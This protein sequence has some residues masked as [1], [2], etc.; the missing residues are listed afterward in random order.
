MK[1]PFD[2]TYDITKQEI[3]NF[4][5]LGRKNRF[6]KLKFSYNDLHPYL[7]KQYMEYIISREKELRSSIK[8][9]HSLLSTISSKFLILIN[10]LFFHE[11]L[12]FSQLDVDT[13]SFLIKLLK[14]EISL[15]EAL[16]TFKKNGRIINL[17]LK[18]KRISKKFLKDILKYDTL[19][20]CVTN[21]VD[22][23]FMAGIVIDYIDISLSFN[24][25]EMD[26]E[27]Q[28]VNCLR[29][30]LKLEY[31]PQSATIIPSIPKELYGSI[32]KIYQLMCSFISGDI[33]EQSIYTF[34]T[35]GE[36]HSLV[37]LP[38]NQV[39]FRENC[40]LLQDINFDS[41]EGIEIFERIVGNRFKYYRFAGFKHCYFDRSIV[42]N[43]KFI[44]SNIYFDDCSFNKTYQVKICK[45]GI[46][47]RFNKCTFFGKVVFGKNASIK[48]LPCNI[49]IR[50][51]IFKPGSSIEIS[52]ITETKGLTFGKVAFL[53]TIFNGNFK[54]TNLSQQANTL[55][56]IHNI[57][58][59]TPFVIENCYFNSDTVIDGLSFAITPKQAMSG[60]IKAFAKTLELSG[61]RNIA[62]ENELLDN[63]MSNN[64]ED[65]EADK[66]MQSYKLE[67]DS[68]FLKPKYAA[69]Y[70]G[71]SKDNLA[72][73]RM[74]DKRQITRESIPYV[75]EGKSIAY[76]LDALKAFKASDWALLK[77]L[78][79]KYAKNES[80]NSD[81]E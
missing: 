1:S 10:E 18:N 22:D 50:D 4:V 74:A 37:P 13:K 52:N 9:V 68:G 78:R 57:A 76:P 34:E 61:L 56:S 53:N 14:K 66:D 48:Y 81:S 11:F 43:D 26:K 29:L 6:D 15:K 17:L 41:E 58:I 12:A 28:L 5:F 25:D 59:T 19:G 23:D 38:E 30:L 69:Y 65:N 44:S 42:L 33:N 32:T 63:E 77:E 27:L 24:E 40:L 75:G 80:A 3:A 54:L 72:K 16:K 51:S 45:P 7:L 47:M 64:S 36:N 20:R 71:M 46:L 70:L 21:G 60:A 39:S 55:F 2:D 73:K 49:E 8:D 79:E 35:K 67:C 62:I 31:S